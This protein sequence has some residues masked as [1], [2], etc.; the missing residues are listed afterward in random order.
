MTGSSLQA[1]AHRAAVSTQDFC[2]ASMLFCGYALLPAAPSAGRGGGRGEEKP[3]FA[4]TLGASALKSGINLGTAQFTALRDSEHSALFPRSLSFVL[5]LEGRSSEF[6]PGGGRSRIVLN[7]GEAA[8]FSFSDAVGTT[9]RYCRGQ[10]SKSVLIQLRSDRIADEGLAD[11]VDARTRDS[12]MLPL[13]TCPQ[14]GFLCGQLFDPTL[15]G[16]AGCLLLESRVLEIVARAIQKLELDA[17]RPVAASGG[18]GRGSDA[19]KMARVR[20]RLM[21]EP[22]GDHSLV[23]LARE[24]GV[25]VSGL[26]TKF[27]AVYG[28]TVFAFLHELRM[29]RARTGLESGGWTVT[30]AAHFTGYR[31]ASNFSTAFQKHFGRSPG[32]GGGHRPCPPA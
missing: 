1:S 30:Q 8:L 31:H 20:D 14:L 5:S 12:G 2:K 28:Q 16:T 27:R 29:E 32:R 4:G 7:P 19:A 10:R 18:G 22:E 17:V 13:G 15:C 26:K 9:G 11:F 24:A 3:L 21:A 6:D 23:A 25:S